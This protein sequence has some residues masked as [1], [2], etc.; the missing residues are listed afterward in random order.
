M[1][2]IHSLNWNGKLNQGKIVM[3]NNKLNKF[4]NLVSDEKSGIH[5]KAAWRKANKGWLKKSANI[6][7]KILDTLR[8]R[9]MSQK[10]L[11]VAME[12][13]PQYISKIVKGQ[14]NLSL[15]AI[16]KLEKA[17]DIELIAIKND[18]TFNNVK[19][20]NIVFPWFQLHNL[21]HQT[22][23]GTGIKNTLSK[24]IKLYYSD[25]FISNTPLVEEKIELLYEKPVVKGENKNEQSS[26]AGE[27][28]YA[29]SA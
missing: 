28:T 11:A 17:L 27:N 14:E 1:T 6:A 19:W 26:P 25:Y 7:L 22:S 21:H 24:S 4:L 8:E 5:E 9:D 2:L 15:E 16:D 18:T 13:T 3:E 10:D 29:M 20:K 23:L 12:V